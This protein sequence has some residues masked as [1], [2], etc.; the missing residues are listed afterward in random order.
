LA[1]VQV[2]PERYQTTG[3]FVPCLCGGTSIEKAIAVSRGLPPE[4]APAEGAQAIYLKTKR[5]SNMMIGIGMPISQ[6]N[7]PFM[8]P[9]L[10][11]CR[12]KR[13]YGRETALDDGWFRCR[14]TS[15]RYMPQSLLPAGS[16]R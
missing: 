2:S 12:K 8:R 5:Y 3:S 9:F 4:L 16:R 13:H 1:W 6:S 11:L 15:E 14:H 10:S 7:I